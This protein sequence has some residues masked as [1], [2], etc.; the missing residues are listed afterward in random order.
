MIVRSLRGRPLLR[1]GLKAMLIWFEFR[2]LKMKEEKLWKFELVLYLYVV[3][4][5]VFVVSLVMGFRDV[6]PLDG[7]FMFSGTV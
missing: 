1:W 6:L 3:Y 7:F 5:V 4:P 2:L